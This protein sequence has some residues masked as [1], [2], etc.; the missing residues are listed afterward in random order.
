MRAHRHAA[1]ARKAG[2]PAG[3]P[4]GRAIGRT[5][6]A[7]DARCRPPAFV[8]TAGQAGDARPPAFDREAYKRRDTVERCVNRLEQW[9]GI[10]TRHEK[11]ATIYQ[12]GPH[13]AGILLRS[14]R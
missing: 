1:G 12:A 9:R 10:A 8:L 13:I 3:E 5:H 7:A 2:A 14:A 6:L 4:A 11:T